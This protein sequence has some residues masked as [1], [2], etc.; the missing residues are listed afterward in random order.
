MSKCGKR[1]VSMW[2]GRVQKNDVH[3]A[4][5]N[6]I[7]IDGAGPLQDTAYMHLQTPSL[8]E[9]GQKV[10]AGQTIGRVGD[11]G[12]ASAC[13]LHF[14]LWSNPGYYEGGSAVDPTPLL[15]S[16]DKKKYINR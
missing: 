15:E 16:L 11:T 9:E 3:S 13:H 2:S 8:L 7:V 6:Y 4:A 10:V 5:G 12:N 14:E 1:I